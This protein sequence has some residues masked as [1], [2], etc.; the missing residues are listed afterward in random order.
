MN[1]K[2]SLISHAF[3]IMLCISCLSINYAH[4][5]E[6]EIINANL[7]HYIPSSSSVFQDIELNATYAFV[8]DAN[9]PG[10]RVISLA[11]PANPSLVASRSVTIATTY[12]IEIANNL[13]YLRVMEDQ[14][15]DIEYINVSNPSVPVYKGLLNLN[16]ARGFD[17]IENYL[18]VNNYTELISYDFTDDNN[19]VELDRLNLT[20]AG[21]SLTIIDN[22]IYTCTSTNVLKIINATEPSTL[23]LMSSTT[24]GDF[25]AD[26]YLIEN[27]TLYVSG[28]D[29]TKTVLP[30]RAHRAHVKSID[31]SNKSNPTLLSDIFIDGI[32]GVGMALLENKLF[33]GACA[34]GL[35][36]VDISDSFSLRL[37]GYY[38]EYQDLY[39]GGD[40][41]SMYPKLFEDSLLG[42]LIAFV[43]SSCGLIIISVDGLE[44]KSTIPGYDLYLLMLAIIAG[45]Y[46]IYKKLRKNVT[47]N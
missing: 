5:D 44:F 41:Y 28:L 6:R 35:K 38:D 3:L 30:E 40:H 13:V 16:H 37:F 24:L 9:L 34:E 1:Q 39:C 31:I 25:Y 21:Q 22:F 2:H 26:S 23:T 45:F 19:P 36:V 18:F 47:R 46:I 7:C 14:D 27:K 29:S 10:L 8:S 20:A 42:N 12:E 32:N 17:A 15:Y 11:N 4:A 33:V 43:S